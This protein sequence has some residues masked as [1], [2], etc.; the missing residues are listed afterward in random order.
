MGS[1]GNVASNPPAGWQSWMQGVQKGDIQ[2]SKL[3]NKACVQ[4]YATP[5]VTH[6]GNLILITDAKNPNVTTYDNNTLL[7]VNQGV[8]N[9]SRGVDFTS[10]ASYNWMCAKSS[11]ELTWDWA[12]SCSS[13]LNDPSEFT[14]DIWTTKLVTNDGSINGNTYTVHIDSCLS[15]TLEEQ[16]TIEASLSL[17]G[18]VI[19]FIFRKL[20]CIFWVFWQLKEHP[21]VVVGDA[22][23]SFIKEPDANT[24]GACLATS[25]NFNHKQSWLSAR[26]W[27]P[28]PRHWSH[29]V[30][31]WQWTTCILL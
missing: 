1:Y 26:K 13:I 23:T 22:I 17:L 5:F 6:S 8:Y 21:L 20:L 30:S 25:S 9:A 16:C 27:S 24:K 3:D 14:I 12:P 28:K 10:Y 29:N 18:I 31:W 4:T 2:L 7:V 19:A 15:Q 11:I